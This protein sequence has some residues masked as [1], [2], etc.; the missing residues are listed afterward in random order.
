MI[1]P[2]AER[3]QQK[4]GAG[5]ARDFA[6]FESTFLLCHPTYW[7]QDF[8]RFHQVHGTVLSMNEQA[9]P[10]GEVNAVYLCQE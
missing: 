3:Q 10:M 8:V 6:D 9:I 2:S 5:L 7:V 4:K 1:T